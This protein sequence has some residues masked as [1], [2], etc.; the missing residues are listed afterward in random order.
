MV[1]CVALADAVEAATGSLGLVKL[2]WPNDLLVNGAKIS[3]ILLESE[4]MADGRL[5]V[6]A[7]IG[8]NCGHHPGD[9]LYATIDLASLGYRVTPDD[10]FSRLAAAMAS[11]LEEWQAGKGFDA[12]RAAWLRR[13]VGIGAP[14]TVRLPDREIEGIFS[15]LDE[16][17]RLLLETNSGTMTISAG[18]VFFSRTAERNKENT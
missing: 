11:R 1:C 5:V 2:K 14:V 3:G 13:C 6:V 9:A 15:A 7:G 17:G 16:D 10:M 4:Y 8:V 12:I 18:D